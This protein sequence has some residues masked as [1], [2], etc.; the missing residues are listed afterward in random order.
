MNTKA[1]RGK[2][3]TRIKA[4]C[5]CT[6]LLA[7]LAAN[8]QMYDYCY[9]EDVN[10]Y[11][12]GYSSLIRGYTS[13]KAIAYYSS[14]GMYY[15]D[16]LI[17]AT[18]IHNRVPIPG[19]LMI[20]DYQILDD[21]VYFCG[22]NLTNNHAI[23]GHFAIGDMGGTVTFNINI[24]DVHSNIY[25]NDVLEVLTRLAVKQVNGAVR[26]MALGHM[27]GRDQTKPMR[28]VLFYP[29][30]GNNNT[31]E[32][33]EFPP[34]DECYMEVVVTEDYFA[35]V[36]FRSLLSETLSIRR[37]PV[38]YGVWNTYPFNTR[39]YY[40]TPYA[41]ID[42]LSATELDNNNIAVSSI[43]LDPTLTNSEAR[44]QVY[45]ISLVSTQMTHLQSFWIKWKADPMDMVY[46]PLIKKLVLV[47][48]LYVENGAS[49]PGFIYLDP[50]PT[51]NYTAFEHRQDNQ[52]A[53][54][55]LSRLTGKHFIAA[56]SNRW[57]YMNQPSLSATATCYDVLNRD[58]KVDNPQNRA[59][60]QLFSSYLGIST[61]DSFQSVVK[62]ST[63]KNPC[64][65][66]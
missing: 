34:N 29:D 56:N 32:V 16:L 40:P 37:Q 18:P 10:F 54:Y 65:E 52:F 9:V 51:A 61:S 28:T 5:L 26:I 3:P 30:Y 64:M 7:A 33:Y 22:E 17:D 11:S 36:G 31:Y 15:F 62:Y 44:T 63:Y 12:T 58:V 20:C 39:N 55:N 6:A 1:N 66:P 27:A 25:N 24:K 8:G 57:F 43:Y 47:E 45:T 23:L 14:G 49:I 59:S 13:N 42:W 19:E 50:Y 48:P 46:L 60:D 4:L 2:S 38:T 53:T 21:Q 35:I 41:C